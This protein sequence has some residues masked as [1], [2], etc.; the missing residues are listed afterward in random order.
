MTGASDEIDELRTSLAE[1]S[2]QMDAYA[3]QLEELSTNMTSQNEKINEEIES[4]EE[5]DQ[6]V[7]G[8]LT[9]IADEIADLREQTEF[10]VGMLQENITDLKSEFDKNQ[11]EIQAQYHLKYQG[12]RL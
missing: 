10:D 12:Y 1:L 7:N 5:F 8:S 6:T 11:L 2:N 3:I 4:L 9:D